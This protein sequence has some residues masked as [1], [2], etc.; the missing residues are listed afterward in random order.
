MEALGAISGPSHWRSGQSEA[1][2]KAW[3]AHLGAILSCNVQ[4]ASQSFACILC[5]GLWGALRIAIL[6]LL[7]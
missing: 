2:S 6:G 1:L 4:K 7:G 3:W 5:L